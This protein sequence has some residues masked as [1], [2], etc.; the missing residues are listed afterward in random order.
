MEAIYCDDSHIYLKCFYKV[1]LETTAQ[2]LTAVLLF[3]E[4]TETNMIGCLWVVTPQRQ[5]KFT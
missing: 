2:L 1:E 5:R 4:G 3:P